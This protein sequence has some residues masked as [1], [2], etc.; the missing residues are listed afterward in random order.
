MIGTGNVDQEWCG[1]SGSEA[2]VKPFMPVLANKLRDLT[3]THPVCLL[4]RELQEKLL[5][6]AK[7][8]TKNLTFLDISF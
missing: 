3:R 6:Q 4:D 8:S 5:I 2:G 1:D 7:S